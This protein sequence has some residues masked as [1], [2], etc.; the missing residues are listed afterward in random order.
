[1]YFSIAC[2]IKQIR[3]TACFNLANLRH[4][5]SL[6]L[7][8]ILQWPCPKATCPIITP[9]SSFCSARTDVSEQEL[10]FLD[11]SWQDWPSSDE[12]ALP[13][14]TI[15]VLKKQGLQ[16]SIKHGIDTFSGNKHYIRFFEDANNG[17][18]QHQLE[19]CLPR[20]ENW[21]AGCHA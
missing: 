6:P 21:I 9:S 7:L 17:Q 19:R 3:L 20:R 1:M 5:Y 14:D 15:F 16:T 13:D 10:L 12:A 4:I 11:N 8:L 18:S 2:T